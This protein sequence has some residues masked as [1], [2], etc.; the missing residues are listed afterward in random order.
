MA[1]KVAMMAQRN[2]QFPGG[3]TPHPGVLC[4]PG[5]YGNVS[6]V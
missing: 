3:Y 5:N 4:K 6:S 2:D 1:V